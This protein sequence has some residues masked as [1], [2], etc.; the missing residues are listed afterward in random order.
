MNRFLKTWIAIK[1]IKQIK[2]PL[3]LNIADA[4]VIIRLADSAFE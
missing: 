3:F 1:F 2:L 4:A